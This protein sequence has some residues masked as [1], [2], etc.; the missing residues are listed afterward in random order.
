MT[1][2]NGNREMV[3]RTSIALDTPQEYAKATIE[4]YATLWQSGEPLVTFTWQAHK[5][6]KNQD[7]YGQAWKEGWSDWYSFHIKVDGY[8]IHGWEEGTKATKAILRAFKDRHSV[9]PLELAERLNRMRNCTETVYDPRVSKLVALDDV[10]PDN[11]SRYTDD[12]E[13]LGR[14]HSAQ[15]CLATSAERARNLIAAALATN[16]KHEEILIKYIEEGRPV[17]QQDRGAPDIT[18]ASEKF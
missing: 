4:V 18:P 1:Q 16:P 2:S 5:L 14:L 17:R 3:F 8:C 11:V 7:Q 12:Y 6:S 9:S 15:S 13:I 10:K